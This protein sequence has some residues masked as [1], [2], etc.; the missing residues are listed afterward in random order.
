MYMI[1]LVD[2]FECEAQS[3]ILKDGNKLG[4]YE[5]K[6]LRKYL[7][8]RGMEFQENG[9]DCKIEFHALR[10]PDDIIEME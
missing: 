6:V 8:Q 1:L 10:V 7:P 5:I 9:E 2:L 3:L 4:V